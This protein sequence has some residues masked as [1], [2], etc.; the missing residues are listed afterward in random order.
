M[1]PNQISPPTERAPARPHRRAPSRS[2]AQPPAYP[3]VRVHVSVF[4]TAA[5]TLVALTFGA[6]GR[7]AAQ[8]CSPRPFPADTAYLAYVPGAVTYCLVD[9]ADLSAYDLTLDGAPVAQG[10]EPSCGT[11]AEPG[12]ALSYDLSG[13][14]GG[15]LGGEV[16]LRRWRAG[17]TILGQR[18]FDDARALAEQLLRWD[19]D[20][21]WRYEE[22]TQRI[23]SDL[24]AGDYSALEIR[25]EAT[26]EEYDLA[27][28][29]VDAPGAAVT[30]PEPGRDYLLVATARDGT[31]EAR[32]VIARRG[33]STG[34]STERYTV[35]RDGDSGLRCVPT[36][37]VPAATETNVCGRA[38][39]GVLQLQ[40]VG[41]FV[42]YPEIGFTGTDRACIVTCGGGVCDTTLLEFAVVPPPVCGTFAVEGATRLEAATCTSG[43]TFRLRRTDEGTDAVTFTVDGAA[44]SATLGDGV[45]A[46]ELPVGTWEVIASAGGDTCGRAFAVEVVCEA[47]VPPCVAPFELTLVGQ[48]VD[49]GRATDEVF[50]PAPPEALAEYA[51]TI[52]GV[53]YGG[54]RSAR[55]DPRDGSAATAIEVPG[56]RQLLRAVE[57]RR[58]SGCAHVF[59][60]ATRCVTP[61]ADTLSLTVGVPGEYCLSRE[62]VYQPL[63][64]PSVVSVA[65]PGLANVTPRDG[66]CVTVTAD[67]SGATDVTLVACTEIGICDTAYVHLRVTTAVDGPEEPSEPRPGGG[68]VAEDDRVVADV[69]GTVT[70][71]LLDNDDAGG[72]VT[73]ATLLSAFR[74]GGGELSPAGFLTYVAG[75]EA[76]GVVD[77]AT[78]SLC[79]DAG[80]DTARV[81]VRIRCDT[82]VAF[83]GFSPN[84]DGVNDAFVIEGLED[85]P[86]ARLLVFNRYGRTVYEAT[87]YASDWDGRAGDR[88]LPDGV[89]FYLLE[90]PGQGEPVTGYVAL[91]R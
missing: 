79:G 23:V 10:T 52:A 6:V 89:Y 77:T 75:E 7:V 29:P 33:A 20:G 32:L 85:H 40:G 47:E 87:D 84:G 86:G 60:L 13:V 22:A 42:Y 67:A 70:A 46:L 3:P 44:A 61:A 76:C 54:P 82:V 4:A 58:D 80:C 12:D 73:T 72:A 30:L 68:P 69:G 91:Y 9:G 18:L 41:C 1:Y 21:G 37:E 45:Y 49:C 57:L 48:G 35:T 38:D 27:L 50:L 31:C 56:P 88:D 25:W 24:T 66:G 39:H 71:D 15:G 17:I 64:E 5:L 26:G 16:Y 34:P 59:Q 81:A 62:E 8:P 65:D 63:G 83:P 53:P 11:F 2:D 78:Y 43:A 36:D 51:L 28:G 74:Y 90:L 19:P 55:T 14:P